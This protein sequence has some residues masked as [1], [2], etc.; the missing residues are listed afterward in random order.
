MFS[1]VITMVLSLLSGQVSVEATG[2]MNLPGSPES[3]TPALDMELRLGTKTE[4]FEDWFMTDSAA[5][6]IDITSS[7]GEEQ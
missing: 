6:S 3:N 1:L 4:G 2:G 5:L 7:G